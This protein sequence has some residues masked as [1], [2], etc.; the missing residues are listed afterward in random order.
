VGANPREQLGETEGLG[1]VVV[2]A[3]F[4]PDDYVHLVTSGRQHDQHAVR[5]AQP[6]LSAHL[7]AVDVRQTQVEQDQLETLPVDQVDRGGS[8][9]RPVDG[10]PIGA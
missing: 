9:P 7:H 6:D 8:R 10:M 2:G 5:V 3:G 1:D 4:E